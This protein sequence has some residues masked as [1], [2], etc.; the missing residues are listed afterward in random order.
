MPDP[1]QTPAVAGD[2]AG[3]RDAA[4]IRMLVADNARMRAA[5]L[6]LS[7]AALRVIRDYDGVHRLSLAVAEWARAVANEGHREAAYAKP[8]QAACAWVEGQVG[9]TGG[10]DAAS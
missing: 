6:A 1:I 4:L 8:D 2:A 5:G 10:H 3:D 7:E 9:G